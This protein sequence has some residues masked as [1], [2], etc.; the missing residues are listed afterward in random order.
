M[1]IKL[2]IA[3]QA[4]DTNR[5]ARLASATVDTSDATL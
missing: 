2:A 1:R 5:V 4:I 3:A